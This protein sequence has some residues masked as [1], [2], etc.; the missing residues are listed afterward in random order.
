MSRDPI[1]DA[2]KEH[3]KEKFNRDRAAFLANAEKDDDG[4]WTK[5]TKY[6]WSRIVNGE[7][8]DYWPSRNKFQYRGKV[9]RGDVMK[10]VRS[11][12]F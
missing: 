3:S 10:I 6:H 5:H 2:M 12:T 4:G 1:W 8:L 11:K 7:R 9:M